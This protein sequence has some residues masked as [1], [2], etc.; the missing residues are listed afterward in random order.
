MSS[1]NE[2]IAI[3][4]ENQASQ[5]IFRLISKTR[6]Q[7]FLNFNKIQT[8][9]TTPDFPKSKVRGAKVALWKVYPFQYKSICIAKGT[10]PFTVQPICIV[11]GITFHSANLAPLAF[12][13]EKSGVV[14]KVCLIF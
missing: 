10:V 13:F 9:Q 8:F 2:N 5:P 7:K 3:F 4:I 11:E 14:W 1:S 6:E 12:D